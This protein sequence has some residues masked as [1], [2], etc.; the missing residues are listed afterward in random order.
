MLSLSAVT[1]SYFG[2]GNVLDQVN[3][4]LKKGDF[5]Y[6]I[7]GSGAGKSTMLRI[8]ATEESPSAGKISLFGYDLNRVSPSTLR[9]IR[10]ALGFIPQGIKL[11]PDLT[12]F[13]NVA[14][15]LSLAGARVMN[16]QTRTQ[17]AELLE[18]LGL[19][20]KSKLLAANLSGGEA[21]RVAVARAL[22]RSPELVIADE[23]TGAQDQ[24]YTWTLMDL[25][26]KA[27]I[28]GATIVIATH[29]REIVRRV[30]KP[31]ATLKGGRIAFE[32]VPC[33]F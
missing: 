8:L 22:V 6:L 16:G 7:G 32:G 17:I 28:A 23:P 12:V 2:Q 11:I 13:D 31:C 15:S 30:Q 1:K 26:H 4:R 19:I 5:L 29:D 3:L 21:Q 27:N 33:I 25:F 20:A 18:R 9:A 10:Q 14:L 24:H